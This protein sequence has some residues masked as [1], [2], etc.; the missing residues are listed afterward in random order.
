MAGRTSS[1]ATATMP[2]GR[3]RPVLGSGAKPPDLPDADDRAG[4]RREGE[5]DVGAALVADGDAAELGEPS[6]GALDFATVSAE[7][8]IAVGATLY[9][10][11][12]DAASAARP[13]AA[14][15]VVGLVGVTFARMRSETRGLPSFTEHYQLW[16]ACR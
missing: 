9:D 5:V 7:T 10:A 6:Q 3:S 15:M 4:E 16:H 1:G 2:A 13:A 12:S 8:L 11:R 14:V